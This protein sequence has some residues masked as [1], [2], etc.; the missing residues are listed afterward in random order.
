MAK[1]LGQMMDDVRTWIGAN[2]KRLPDAVLATI[3]NGIVRDVSSITDGFMFEKVYYFTTTASQFMY[4]FPEGFSRPFSV[5]YGEHDGTV[6]ASTGTFTVPGALYGTMESPLTYVSQEEYE[7]DYI[8]ADSGAPSVYSMWADKLYIG[9]PSDGQYNVMMKLYTLSTD[10]AARNES[11]VFIE[12]YWDV[13]LFGSLADASKYLMEDQRI[14]VFQSEY[15]LRK[16]RMQ[17]ELSH[18]KSSGSR[19]ESRIPGVVR[20]S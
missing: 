20:S 16:R 8:N 4:D 3:V 7:N 11:N 9:P 6:S 15:E 17:I 14:G 5:W 1:N 13:V 12:R 19:P 10:L 18:M 2:Q